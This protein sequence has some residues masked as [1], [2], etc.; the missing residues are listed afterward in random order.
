MPQWSVRNQAWVATPRPKIEL[1]T[2][3]DVATSRLS[4]R[5]AATSAGPSE[6]QPLISPKSTRNHRWPPDAHE[7]HNPSSPSKTSAAPID[8]ASP[9][10]NPFLP[11]W[12]DAPPESLHKVASKSNVVANLWLKSQPLMEVAEPWAGTAKRR[13]SYQMS[14]HKTYELDSDVVAHLR[15]FQRLRVLSTRS[16]PD[17]T[18]RACI[19]LES[20]G[21]LLGWLTATT[22]DGIA[23]IHLYA[24]PLYEV[25]TPTKVR[26]KFELTSKFVTQLEEGTKLHVVESR[27]LLEGTL[28]VCVM[29]VGNPWG[30][31]AKCGPIG[32]IT[33]N[34]NEDGVRLI[35]ETNV[36]HADSIP[37]RPRTASAFVGE[38]QRP[39]PARPFST[40][41]TDR[42][43]AQRRE[44][45]DDDDPRVSLT[46]RGSLSDELNEASS[47]SRR[48]PKSER[49]GGSG[50]PQGR[51]PAG[52]RN[53]DSF[54]RS[55]KTLTSP[56]A[57]NPTDAITF[58]GV[59][60]GVPSSTVET[61][62]TASFKMKKP[63]G[64]SAMKMNQA[65]KTMKEEGSKKSRVDELLP[66]GSIRKVANELFEKA[67]DLETKAIRGRKPLTVQMG[68][69]LQKRKVVVADLM[70][71]WD[72]NGDGEISPMEF[73]QNV[74]KLLPTELHAG[75]VISEVDALFNDLDLDKSG[76]L[77]VG[78]IKIAL[79]RLQN[80]AALASVDKANMLLEV[81]ALRKQAK[82]Y[83]SLASLTGELEGAKKAIEKANSK[84]VGVQIGAIAVKKG[85]KPSDIVKQWDVNGDGRLDK[86]EVTPRLDEFRTSDAIISH[87]M[88]PPFRL[89]RFLTACAPSSP[90]AAVS[91]MRPEIRGGGGEDD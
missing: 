76:A 56:T 24:R 62:T 8:T 88:S 53:S 67:L 14:V 58:S 10:H 5:F 28:R 23:N 36:P 85:L 86:D 3:Y 61:P 59:E 30:M 52:S 75:L 12:K 63:A 26:E 78:E 33:A 46:P 7:L 6:P 43:L 47:S 89:P 37:F 19:M 55:Q 81:E 41:L 25:A 54:R 72:P 68:E 22:A 17:G 50:G 73:R 13:A 18:E 16:L 4:S 2:P 42:R 84:S 57:S 69:A 51:T 31:N 80:E 27:K 1:Q 90:A 40:G 39:K 48:T 34:R 91:H 21:K 82:E 29:L 79:K 65:S 45:D 60:E 15:P 66:S 35:R 38:H 70:R 71:E 11:L 9:V 83:E 20:N 49:S 77:D 32:W 87:C 64:Q 74:R 44:A